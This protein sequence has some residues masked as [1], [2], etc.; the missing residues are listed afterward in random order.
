MKVVTSN[1]AYD[2]IAYSLD[3]LS[4]S[5]LV[6]SIQNHQ[7]K[8]PSS[9]NRVEHYLITPAD[10][11][12]SNGQLRPQALPIQ[13]NQILITNP[14]SSSSSLQA[15]HSSSKMSCGKTGSNMKCHEHNKARK[16]IN[17]KRPETRK[18][19][20]QKMKSLLSPCRQCWTVKQGAVKAQNI[21]R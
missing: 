17:K 2:S 12:I 1:V 18:W 14:P 7:P 8:A 9:P 13:T 16:H 21:P 15:T 5:G 20:G 4:F 10:K 6:S 3:S 11:L 19:F